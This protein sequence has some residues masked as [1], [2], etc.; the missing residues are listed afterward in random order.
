M[1]T[2]KTTISVKHTL[3]HLPQFALNC[4]IDELCK[5]VS[6]S[7]FQELAARYEEVRWVAESLTLGQGRAVRVGNKAAVVQLVMSP[8]SRRCWLRS[9]VEH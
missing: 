4:P 6:R 7:D 5:I 9:G 3:A 8:P 1:P 2:T